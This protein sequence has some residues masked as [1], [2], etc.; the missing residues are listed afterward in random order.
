MVGYKWVFK[1]KVNVDGSFQ[2][3]KAKLAAKGFNQ[4]EGFYYNETFS[5]VVKPTIIRVVLTLAVSSNWPIHQIDIV[6]DFLN[7]DL[8]E[9]VYMQQPLVKGNSNLVCK[10]YKA[11]YGLKQAPRSWYHKLSSTLQ[12]LGFSSTKSDSS[13]FVLFGNSSTLFVLVYVDNIIITWTSSKAINSLASLLRNS[14]SLKDLGPLHYLLLK[15][16]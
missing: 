11:T 4:A 15:L 3:H 6:N 5:P 13:C 9:I 12:K 16:L 2:R 7:G 10:L 14:F 1:N 8:E